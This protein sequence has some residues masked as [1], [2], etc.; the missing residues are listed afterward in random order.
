MIRTRDLMLVTLVLAACSSSSAKN[1][2]GS[3]GS[4]GTG[5]A[6]GT[7]GKT[8]G[9]A[10]GAASGTGGTAAG[11]GGKSVTAGTGGAT[12]NMM[13]SDAGS[14]AGRIAC[15]TTPTGC[16]PAGGSPICDLANNR[17]VECLADTSCTDPTSA[18]CDV[19]GGTCET[20]VT[21]AH[22][23]AGE[24]CQNNNCLATC[25][26]DAMCTADGGGAKPYCNTTMTICVGCVTDAHCAANVATPFCSATRNRCVQC[27]TA[28]DCMAGMTCATN[29]SCRAPRDGG[30]GGQGMDT[31]ADAS[32]AG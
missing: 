17:C 6:V 11:T 4:V 27:R 29:G 14:D 8:S 23:G 31:P 21:N 24:I 2:Q 22:C 32:S 3:G 1:P 15:G 28:A 19:T 9:A 10:G 18:H 13:E 20:C 7:G 26:S 16:N 12:G 30:A 25:T 5:G